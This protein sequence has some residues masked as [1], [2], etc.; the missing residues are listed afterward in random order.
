MLDRLTNNGPAFRRVEKAWVNPAHPLA[1]AL[2]RAGWR[3]SQTPA[4]LRI[5][6]DGVWSSQKACGSG[7]GPL[8]KTR[9]RQDASTSRSRFLRRS[10]VRGASAIQ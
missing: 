3:C 6:A 9:S 7:S 4:Q 5:R 1:T 8:D 2:R 10:W